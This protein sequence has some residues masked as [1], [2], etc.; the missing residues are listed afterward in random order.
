MPLM[1]FN[2]DFFNGIY[3]FGTVLFFLSVGYMLFYNQK[4][5]I[6]KI[7]PNLKPKENHGKIVVGN[8]ERELMLKRELEN[9]ANK[10]AFSDMIKPVAPPLNTSTAIPVVKEETQLELFSG[11]KVVDVEERLNR[12][13][14]LLKEITPL[15]ATA[16]LRAKTLMFLVENE[17]SSVS[18]VKR[19]P[20]VDLIKQ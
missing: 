7:P 19:D 4:E 13:V 17:G 5:Q 10:F 14:L 20:S 12:A 18:P 16:D 11:K 3:V 8:P 15:L 9:R 1:N 2:D 6:G